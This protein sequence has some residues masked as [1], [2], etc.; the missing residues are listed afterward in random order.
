MSQI[1]DIR[2]CW[3]CVNA[4]LP[5][6]S[7]INYVDRKIKVSFKMQMWGCVW[8]VYVL[9]WSP[10]RYFYSDL[11]DCVALD[12]FSHYILFPFLHFLG[13]V[14]LFHL[15]IN[16]ATDF[17]DHKMQVASCLISLKVE[18]SPALS[19]NLSGAPLIKIVLTHVLVRIAHVM[20]QL[21]S[22]WLWHCY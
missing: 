7:V 10:D 2:W 21:H 5:V 17:K 9:M 14:S 20:C 16:E 6:V 11:Y 13:L 18:P 15:R 3:K 8:L 1:P 4:F 12:L 19:V 22:I